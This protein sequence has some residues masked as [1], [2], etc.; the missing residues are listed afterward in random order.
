LK[1][2]WKEEN[3][4][5]SGE[6]SINLLK[7]ALQKLGGEDESELK[8]LSNFNNI[9]PK[10]SKNQISKTPT[11]SCSRRQQNLKKLEEEKKG[12]S[13]RGKN[14]VS[15]NSQQEGQVVQVGSSSSQKPRHKKSNSSLKR[16]L[17]EN[18]LPHLKNKQ[19]LFEVVSNIHNSSNILSF[20]SY[21]F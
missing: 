6:L 2:E 4:D 10:T 13:W 7:R 12:M 9:T 8:N 15:P 21:H 20:C 11:K 1:D 14:L 3:A 16:F 5:V 18:Q 17:N 19:Y